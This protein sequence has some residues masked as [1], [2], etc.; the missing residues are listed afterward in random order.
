MILVEWSRILRG[1]RA[2]TRVPVFEGI[3][4]VIF[5]GNNYIKKTRAN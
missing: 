1:L 4:E 3:L 5:E 2:L